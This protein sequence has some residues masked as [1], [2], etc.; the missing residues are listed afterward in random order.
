MPHARVTGTAWDRDKQDYAFTHDLDLAGWAWEFLR[1]HGGYRSDA[2][3]NRAGAPVTI[4]HVSGASLY[5]PGRRFLAAEAWGLALFADPEKTVIETDVFWLP[6]QLKHAVRCQCKPSNDNAGNSVSLASFHGR[7]AILAGQRHELIS[8]TGVRQSA[9]LLVTQ[10]S[11]LVGCSTVTFLHEGLATASRH[12]ETLTILRH[13]TTETAN[14]ATAKL[15]LDS[16]YL[17]YLIALDGYLEARTYRD[18]AEVLYGRDRVGAHWTEET[19]WMKSKVRR[20]VERG[21][22]LMNGGYRDLL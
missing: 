12:H 22:A 3:L 6:E 13:L 4:Q 16:K 10:G 21:I 2:R 18:I 20:A 17:A 19:R 9:S 11:L 14:T 5:R 15:S 8:V 1:R 7:R